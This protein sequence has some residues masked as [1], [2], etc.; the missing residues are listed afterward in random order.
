MFSTFF[1]SNSDR[2]EVRDSCGPHG[3]RGGHG[4]HER[5]FGGGWEKHGHGPWGR[6]GFGGGRERLFDSGELQF[7]ILKFLAERPSYGYELIKAIEE[8]LAGGYAP[9]PGV[10]YPTLTLLEERGL[11]EVVSSEGNRK[12]YGI[13]EAGKQELSANRARLDAIF[14][15]IEHSGRRFGRER[16]PEI[17]RAFRNLGE[18][19]RGRMMRGENFTPE[20]ITKI[21]Q[22]INDAAR[23]I[24]GV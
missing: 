17:M 9:S 23:T 13:T 10:I 1:R 14:D 8:R 20:Q 12:V 19:I 6:G 21:A 2:G 7:V 3:P 24:D 22:A 18:A 16:S 11:T 5:G 15:R 4:R